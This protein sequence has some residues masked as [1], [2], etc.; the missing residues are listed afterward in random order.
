[1]TGPSCALI[2]S[3]HSN[4]AAEVKKIEP[5]KNTIPSTWEPTTSTN[6]GNGPMKKQVDPNANRTPIHHETRHGAHQT[7]AACPARRDVRL[8]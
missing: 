8:R 3:S 7:P 4:A 6:P 5:T 1:M 2:V